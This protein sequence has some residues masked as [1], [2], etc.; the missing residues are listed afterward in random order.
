MIRRIEAHNYRSLRVVS[1]ALRPFQVLVGPNGS[2]KST[3]LDVLA[4]LS[5]FV[6]LGME[7]ALIGNSGRARRLDELIFN[8]CATSFEVAVEFE[9]PTDLASLKRNGSSRYDFARYEVAFCKA[10]N[11]QLDV[12]SERLWLIES[13]QKQERRL[14]VK[15]GSTA[16]SYMSENSQDELSFK[17]GFGKAALSGVPEDRER[18]PIAIWV[19]DLLLESIRVLALNSAAMRRPVSPSARRDFNV[20]GAN[21]PLVVQDLAKYPLNYADW[22]AHVQTILPDVKQI[23][24]YERPED[25]HLYLAIEYTSTTEPI[26]SWLVSDGTLRL[27]A[28]T[29]LAYLPDEP[30]IYLIEEPENGIHP[31][32][33]EGVYQ[34]L[35]SVYHGQV[36]IATHSPLLLGLA[37]QKQLLIFSKSVSGAV[38]IVSG[39]KHPALANWHG[40]IDLATLY[41][42]GVLG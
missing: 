23:H 33:I 18:F 19:R 2:G 37:E 14:V 4:L 17:L 41:A 10:A 32:A 40:Q 16:N 35:S 13:Q 25:R 5:D 24:V 8:Q 29:I 15:K 36:I 9:I 31:K 34:S 38:E 39:D 20:S 1:Q 42:A 21:L 3:F 28:L 22:L 27:L 30:R 6:R 12:Q 7:E 26:P 11:G